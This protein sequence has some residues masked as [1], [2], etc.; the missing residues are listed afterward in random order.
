MHQPQRPAAEWGEPDD[1]P[2]ARSRD[3]ETDDGVGL[4]TSAN[5]PDVSDP[6]HWL[7]LCA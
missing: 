1:I 3:P 2:P 7:D 6:Q 4:R 5:Q